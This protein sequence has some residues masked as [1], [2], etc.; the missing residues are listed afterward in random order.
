MDDKHKKIKQPNCNDTSIQFEN[1]IAESFIDAIRKVICTGERDTHTDNA[2]KNFFKCF[3]QKINIYTNAAL[4]KWADKSKF[5]DIQMEDIRE[6]LGE[7][8][9]FK[10]I[11]WKND[12]E[13]KDKPFA[14]YLNKVIQTGTIDATKQLHIRKRVELPDKQ[15]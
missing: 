11:Q 12:D 1:K 7:K 3:G 15:R 10:L 8:K 14:A 2:C 4:L 5:G 13:Y 9:I 6:F